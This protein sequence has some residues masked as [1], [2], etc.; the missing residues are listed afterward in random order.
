MS[1]QWRVLDIV[2]DVRVRVALSPPRLSDRNTECEHHRRTTEEQKLRCLER[3]RPNQLAARGQRSPVGY[4]GEGENFGTQNQRPGWCEVS[5]LLT[6][7][8]LLRVACRS[9]TPRTVAWCR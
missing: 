8:R 3:R 4:A 1:E 7:G 9:D 5:W 2:I 6:R